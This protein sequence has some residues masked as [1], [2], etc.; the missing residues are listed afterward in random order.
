M[1]IVMNFELCKEKKDV[2]YSFLYYFVFLVEKCEE[3]N[4]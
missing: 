3:K 4:Q 2:L 1:K